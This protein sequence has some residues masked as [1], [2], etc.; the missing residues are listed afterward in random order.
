MWRRP[1]APAPDA[2]LEPRPEPTAPIGIERPSVTAADE[3]A[4]GWVRS[5]VG[6]VGDDTPTGE[7]PAV[8]DP[9]PV[10]G[11]PLPGRAARRRRPW[12]VWTRRV[13]LTVLG[14]SVLAAAYYGFTLYQV[15]SA[16]RH[17][18]A[19]AVDAIVVMGAANYDGRPSP[20]LQA[21]LDHALELY[22]A[23]LARYIVVT[24]GKQPG[25]RFTE[26]TASRRYLVKKG[27]PDT[28]ILAEDTGRSSWQSLQAVS[29][30][31]R[32]RFTKPRVLIVTDPF[33][34]LR[35]RLIAGEVGLRAYT[36]PTRT[37][38]WGSSTQFKHSLKEAA[39]ISVGRII[40]FHRLWK[41]TG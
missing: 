38:P 16:G 22:T 7:L 27:V 21:R 1:G 35:C 34:S 31:L 32:K 39:G 11:A 6:I 23:K 40:G 2:D 28:A 36:S 37:S 13:L 8:A 12:W 9:T 25:D 30:L 41:V 5:D 33:H 4:G 17:D 15:W 10:H 14:L 3:A 19:R 26:A 18:Q 24:G 29:T 20:L